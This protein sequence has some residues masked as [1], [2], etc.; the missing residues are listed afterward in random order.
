MDATEEGQM[1][2]SQTGQ[3]LESNEILDCEI[4]TWLYAVRFHVL[5]TLISPVNQRQNINTRILFF[6]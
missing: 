3:E 2:F 6:S 5:K 4:L 1:G